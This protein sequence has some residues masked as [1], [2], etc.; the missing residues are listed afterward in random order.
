[1]FQVLFSYHPTALFS[2]SAEYPLFASLFSWSRLSL[3]CAIILDYVVYLS[4]AVAE[5]EIPTQ[6]VIA[7]VL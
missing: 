4:V 3:I 1:M 7:C 5:T 6:V 2:W